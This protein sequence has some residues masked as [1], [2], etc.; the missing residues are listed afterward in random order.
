MKLSLICDIVIYNIHLVI[1]LFA[2]TELPQ[3]GIS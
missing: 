1:V 2:G 3:L